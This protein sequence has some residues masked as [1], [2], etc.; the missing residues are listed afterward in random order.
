MANEEVKAITNLIRMLADSFRA[1]NTNLTDVAKSLR[2]LSDEIE[3]KNRKDEDYWHP[4]IGPDAETSKPKY[5]WVLV[6]IRDDQNILKGSNC[7]VYNVPHI[8]EE[9]YD[10]KM[11]YRWWPL[12]WDAPYGTEEVPFEVVEWKPIS[13]DSCVLSRRNG[14]LVGEAH[15][16]E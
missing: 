11:G 10:E 1:V 13:G 15:S 7:G 9:R 5:D 16:Y 6:K 4:A 8:A 3:K 14:L 2:K 12:E